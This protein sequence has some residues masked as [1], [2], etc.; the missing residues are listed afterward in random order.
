MAQEQLQE[1]ARP[2]TAEERVESYVARNAREGEHLCGQ[3]GTPLRTPREQSA[4]LCSWCEE[5]HAKAG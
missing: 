1:Q 2:D 5:S 3:C 4:R